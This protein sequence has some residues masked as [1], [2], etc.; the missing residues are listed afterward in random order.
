MVITQTKGGH[1]V[2]KGHMPSN[3][4]SLHPATMR[5]HS[6][7]LTPGGPTGSLLVMNDCW[8]EGKQETCVFVLMSDSSVSL[9][10]IMFQRVRN[11]HTNNKNKAKQ[12]ALLSS[13]DTEFSHV[14]R[15]AAF[16][17]LFYGAQCLNATPFAPRGFVSGVF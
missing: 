15:E 4:Y 1:T 8:F 12:D 17:K 7:C 13:P 3:L 9:Q 2:L 16:K 5:I 6:T 11:I 10:N 14:H